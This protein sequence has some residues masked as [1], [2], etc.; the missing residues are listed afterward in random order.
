MGRLKSVPGKYWGVVDHLR[1][2][3]RGGALEPGTRLPSFA[4]LQ[5]RFGA[6]TTTISR[7]FLTL[8]QEGLVVRQQGRGVFVAEPKPRARHHVIGVFGHDIEDQI[9]GY[10]ALL[11]A[12]ARARAHR[13]GSEIL[14]LD[15]PPS[16]GWAK[17]DG[18]LLHGGEGASALD[19]L[20]VQIPAVTLMW[21][22]A[23]CPSVSTDD[24]Q[25][26]RR[27]TQHLLDLGHRRIA[28]MGF[29]HSVPAAIRMAGYEN[30]LHT[31]NVPIDG[32]LEKNM[33][34]LGS[35]LHCGRLTMEQW[36]GEEWRGLGCTALVAQNDH[37]AMG[38]MQAL[39]AAG[40]RIPEDVSVVGFDGTY[41]CEM[42]SPRLTTAEVPLAQLGERAVGML[43]ERIGGRT[44]DIES[45]VLPAPLV[46]RESTAK[47]H[48]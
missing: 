45:I 17:V 27:L 35:M 46:V 6:A 26:S 24:F 1:E 34:A 44:G 41:E 30:A 18:L 7:A 2:L 33:L 39:I 13:D 14:L 25:A 4:E 29:T 38:A 5:E 19:S 32:R 10:Y 47:C 22:F 23:D 9:H 42:C 48:G 31:A 8:E 12:G 36:L 11:L 15:A 43:L 20:P 3:I 16:G 28:Y 21:A 37:V 40:M